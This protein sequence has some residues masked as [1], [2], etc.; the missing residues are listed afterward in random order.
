MREL[1]VELQDLV[2]REKIGLGLRDAETLFDLFTKHLDSKGLATR[3]QS[4]EGVELTTEKRTDERD[5]SLAPAFDE[6]YELR[7]CFPRSYPEPP[8]FRSRVPPCLATRLV[9]QAPQA[10][11][12]REPGDSGPERPKDIVVLAG[13]GA[14]SSQ[15][16]I[17]G[18]RES[19]EDRKQNFSNCFGVMSGKASQ[20]QAIPKKH[21]CRR[22]RR[23]GMARCARGNARSSARP[24]ARE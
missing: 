20:A 14:D 4:L 6:G 23:S 18:C 17:L 15:S 1:T 19:L 7:S 3:E 10:L 24:C 13:V 9:H 22:L 11:G 21:P 2:S 16:P 5:V 12:S 8:E